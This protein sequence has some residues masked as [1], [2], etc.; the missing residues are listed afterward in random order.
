MRAMLEINPTLRLPNVM[1]FVPL[2]SD[3]SARY[4]DGLRKVGLPE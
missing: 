2:R 1:D 3:D 4:F